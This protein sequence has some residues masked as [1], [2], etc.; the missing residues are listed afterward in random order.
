MCFPPALG[1][2]VPNQRGGWAPRAQGD[3]DV[4]PLALMDVRVCNAIR[5]ALAG[6]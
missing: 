2:T 1:E 3:G 6:P 4:N 5:L